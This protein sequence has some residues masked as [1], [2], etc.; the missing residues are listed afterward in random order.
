MT[1]KKINSGYFALTYDDFRNRAKNASLSKYEKIGF[2]NEY[3]EG[4]E[5]K[6]FEDILSKV[7]NLNGKNRLFLDIGSGCSNLPHYLIEHCQSNKHQLLAIDSQEMLEH[8]PDN[9]ALIKI[10]AIYPKCESL[11]ANYSEKLSGIIVYSV[12]QYIFIEGNIWEFIDKSLRLLAP[13]GQ[14]LIG[15]IPNISKR[16]RFFSSRKGIEYHQQFM[17][18]DKKP[19]VEFNKIEEGQIDDSIVFSIIQRVR[20]QGFDAYIL[21]QADNLPMANRREDILIIRP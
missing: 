18:T 11:F 3:R 13:G 14:I 21:P 10:P 15:D 8:L 4:K 9:P 6:I 7:T 19:E 20:L 12:L 1:E 16:K 17:K 2:P 5:R